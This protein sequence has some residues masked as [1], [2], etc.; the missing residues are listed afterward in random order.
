NR[1]PGAPLF[2]QD[3]NCH[4]FD[5]TTTFV[6]NPAAWSDPAPGQFGTSAAYYSD[7]RYQRHPQENL[8]LGRTFRI[9]ERASFNVRMEVSNIFNRAQMPN[10]SVSNAQ[11]SQTKNGAGIA[12]AGFGFIATATTGASTSVGTPTSRQGAIVARLV[13]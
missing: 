3:L 4:C 10:P 1:V 7:Y 11:Q 5:P 6:L 13:F 8:A 12:T 9:K 2:N